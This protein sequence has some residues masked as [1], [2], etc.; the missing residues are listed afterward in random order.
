MAGRAARRRG[1]EAVKTNAVLRCDPLSH[2]MNL[3]KERKVLA[4]L[5]GWRR[6]AATAAALQWRDFHAT[7]RFD[8]TADPAKAFRKAHQ[9]AN[10]VPRAAILEAIV[11]HHGLDRPQP[12]SVDDP[13]R[14]YRR[15]HTPPG[16]VDPLA[17]H[18][19]AIGTAPVAM[20]RRQ[21]VGML[22][23]FVSN[24]QNDFIDIVHGSNLDPVIRHMLLAVNKARAWQALDRP[25][26]AKRPEGRVL[27]PAETRLLARAIWRHVMRGHR[28]PSTKRIGMSVD[29]RIVS[30]LPAHSASGFKLWLRLA[31]PHQG[32]VE[33]PLRETER[34]RERNGNRCSTFQISQDRHDGRIKV[35]VMTDVAET[36]EKTREAYAKKS[37]GVGVEALSLD[38][39]LST[40]FASDMGDLFGRGF[41]RRLRSI[42]A[43]VTGIARHWQRSNPGRRLR[44]SA[45]YNAQVAR[46]RGYVET[47]INAALNRAVA[48]RLPRK[49]VLERLDF[50][51]PGLSARMNRL[52]QNCGRRAVADKLKALEQELGIA[53]TQV[54]AAYT[55][56]TCSAPGCGYVDKRNRR[57]QSQ[58][59]CL[60]CGLH[61]HADVNA[62]RN[63]G[64]GRSLP[65]EGAGTAGGRREILDGLV[66]RHVER[67]PS[68][69]MLRPLGRNGSARRPA[70]PRPDNPY[71]R[72]RE[73]ARSTAWSGSDMENRTRQGRGL[74]SPTLKS[75]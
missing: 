56:Q 47:E 17:P 54:R 40:L 75:G 10:A 68:E 23:S 26:H 13:K 50:R 34:L 73:L 48:A 30:L 66:Q 63:A 36:C 37:A 20:V 12:P 25:V 42:D 57:S 33:I 21:V 38:F 43:T 53:T 39:G 51:N 61:I 14:V 52:V 62:A 41:I 16:L 29:K 1:E 31:I 60:W 59:T 22:E 67:W 35:G 6:C 69:R 24:R 32:I 49:L 5:A 58:F 45:R 44:E 7:S 72:R 55:S 46:L 3:G 4:F 19:A 2:A 65:T 71:F 8:A 64:E 28:K 11:A 9:R 27:V 15:L 74:S 70:D 18:K